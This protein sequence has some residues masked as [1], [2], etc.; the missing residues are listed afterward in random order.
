MENRWVFLE[1]GLRFALQMPIAIRLQTCTLEPCNAVK[2]WWS[3]D[4]FSWSDCG[5]IG[6]LPI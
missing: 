1:T 5:F 2:S 3:M 4:F 6:Y